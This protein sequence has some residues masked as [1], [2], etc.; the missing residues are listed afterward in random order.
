MKI[1]RLVFFVFVYSPYNIMII[2][3]ANG[4]VFKEKMK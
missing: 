2:L 3:N 4:T 1:G